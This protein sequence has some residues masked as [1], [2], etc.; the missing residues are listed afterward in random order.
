MQV[1]GYSISAQYAY[2]NVVASYSAT[3]LSV[4]G[5]QVRVIEV[6]TDALSDNTT[7]ENFIDKNTGVASDNIIDFS[8]SNPFGED[9]F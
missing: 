2:Q 8:Q 5:Q 4:D 7:F 3:E 1:N 6:P 9:I